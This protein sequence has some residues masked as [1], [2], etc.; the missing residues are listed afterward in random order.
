MTDGISAGAL[1]NLLGM[2]TPEDKIRWREGPGG[3]QLAYI[4]ARLVMDILDSALVG[5]ANWQCAYL[6]GPSEKVA[7][8]IGIHVDGEWLWKWDGAG[9]TDIEGEKGSFSDAFKRAAVRWGIGRDLY[10]LRPQSSSQRPPA[11]PQP[12]PAPAQAGGGTFSP[13]G[14][15]DLTAGLDDAEPPVCPYH[16]KPATRSKFA[17]KVTGVIGWYCREKASN[18]SPEN[19]KGYCG[20]KA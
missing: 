9:E 12:P 6:F 17:D 4:D 18:G 20:W 16:H 7:C 10:A 11:A 5:P 15:N 13:I 8:G 2:K 19:S 1:D 3:K 14:S